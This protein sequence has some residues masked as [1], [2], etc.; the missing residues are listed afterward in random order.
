[1]TDTPGWLSDAVVAFGVACGEKLAGPG[2]AEAAIRS[3]LEALLGAAG[4]ALKVKAGPSDRKPRY[5]L[6]HEQRALDI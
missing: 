2:E 3:P 4:S 5:G 6:P 1:L